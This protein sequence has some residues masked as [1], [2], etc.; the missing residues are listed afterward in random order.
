[1]RSNGAAANEVGDVQEH[2]Q[3]ERCWLT[4]AR[5]YEL[6]EHIGRFSD[7]IGRRRVRVLIAPNPP[8]PAI[9][10]VRCSGAISERGWPSLYLAFPQLAVPI[11]GRSL[12]NAA[13]AASKSWIGHTLQ[14]VPKRAQVRCIMRD[15]D[16]RRSVWPVT[17]TLT[18][19]AGAFV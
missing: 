18:S 13:L 6:S 8:D 3:I 5:S 19:M 16:Q 12:A 2:L 11:L 10:I 14:H 17:V 4:L 15:H 1:L 9:P 7:E